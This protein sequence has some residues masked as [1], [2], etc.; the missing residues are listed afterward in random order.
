MSAP[1]FIAGQL[2]DLGV[3][4]VCVDSNDSALGPR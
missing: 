4:V 2:H 1:S 3:D